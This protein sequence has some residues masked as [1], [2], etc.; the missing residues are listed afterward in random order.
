MAGFCFAAG[1]DF[2]VGGLLASAFAGV[3]WPAPIGGGLFIVGWVALA[4]A[5]VVAYCA[6]R[7]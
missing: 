3:G 2:F 5:G 6:R 1:I 7:A 4:G